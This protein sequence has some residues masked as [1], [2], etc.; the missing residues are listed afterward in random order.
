MRRAL[1]IVTAAVVLCAGAALAMGLFAPGL[2]GLA[3]WCA[4]VLVLLAI[5]RVRYK[6]I[7]TAPP[8]GEGWADTGERMIDP[9]TRRKLGVWH[10]A[11]TGERAYVDV[12][13]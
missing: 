3:I 1:L 11:T 4:V 5:E 6:A 9:S 12:G 8:V 2:A 7:L 10:R 13:G